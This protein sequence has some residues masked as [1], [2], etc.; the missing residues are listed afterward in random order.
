[1][2]RGR[3]GTVKSYFKNFMSNFVTKKFSC[4][5]DP[6]LAEAQYVKLR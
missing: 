1:M 2:C 4:G 5:K 3:K 6:L